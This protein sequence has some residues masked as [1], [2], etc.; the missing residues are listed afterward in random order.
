[1]NPH[2]RISRAE[3]Y[4]QLAMYDEAMLELEEIDY[5][6]RLSKAVLESRWRIY[7]DAECWMG[8]SAMADAMAKRTPDSSEW[9]IRKAQALRMEQGADAALAYLLEES[10]EKDPAYSYEIGRFKCLTGDFAGARI[11]VKKAFEL[12][13]KFR[14]K[15][16][17][18]DD[19][20][21][22]WDSFGEE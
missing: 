21:G 1:M 14:A 9:R 20:D 12:D 7:R 18:D 8:A 13:R 2:T 3:G 4:R 16:V 11:A 6:D 15:F 17:E 10:F 5:E 22:V 19:F